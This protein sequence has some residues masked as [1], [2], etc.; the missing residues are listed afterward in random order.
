MND[1]QIV[2]LYFHRDQ[3]AIT[4][5]REKYDRYC[6]TIANNILSSREDSEECVSDTYLELW[7]NIPP[8]RPVS[9]KA[10]AG[11]LT[12]NNALKRGGGET[13]ACIDELAECLSLGT[14]P[15]SP[16][17]RLNHEHLVTC[18][19][20]FLSGIKREQRIIFLR[21]YWYS[22]SVKEISESL[23]ISESKVKVTLMRLREKLKEYLE[24]EGVFI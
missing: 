1:S 19:N 14:D 13:A 8:T 18:I 9:L 16:E 4:C 10:F 24:R 5:T 7:N 22:S 6:M 20:R 11:R 23:G 15:N 12:K 3:Q 17:E 21:R 2:E